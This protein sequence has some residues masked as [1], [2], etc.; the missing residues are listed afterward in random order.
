MLVVFIM[1]NLKID[2]IK[3]FWNTNKYKIVSVIIFVI[4][5]IPSITMPNL[6]NN[7]AKK[8]FDNLDLPEMPEIKVTETARQAL[9]FGNLKNDTTLPE[10]KPSKIVIPSESSEEV[11]PQ[12]LQI[13]QD[14][15]SLQMNQSSTAKGTIYMEKSELS[16]MVSDKF[17]LNSTVK[18]TY[19]DKSTIQKIGSKRTLTSQTMGIVNQEVFRKLGV[20]SDKIDSIEVTIEQI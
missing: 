14:L 16:E 15:Q 10:L 2:S 7:S 6:I 1:I 4:L 20:D 17:P 11:N 8:T 5:V 13:K 12:N 18:I 3:L 9:N 19:K